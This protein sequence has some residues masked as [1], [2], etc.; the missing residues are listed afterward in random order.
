MAQWLRICL[1]MQG[2]WLQALV[3]EDPTCSG[4]IKPVYHNCWACALE[5]AGHNYWAHVL[6]SPCTTTTEPTCHNYWSPSSLGP[7]CHNYW[8]CVLQPL[9]PACLEPVLHNKRSHPMRSPHTAT[10]SSP[11]SPHLE[12]AHSQQWRPNPA[13]K[14]KKKEGKI[15]GGFL[16]RTAHSS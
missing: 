8:A 5:P 2:T 13:Q 14:K 7:T 1:P 11:R 10:K 15:F 12:K 4:A 6:W 16:S 9:K 3:R